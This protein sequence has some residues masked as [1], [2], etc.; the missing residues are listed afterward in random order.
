MDNTPVDMPI[1]MERPPSMREL[2]QE[3][4]EGALS[5]RAQDEQMGTFEEEDD[6]EAD[7][8]D[9]LDL[10]GFEVF[11]HPMAEEDE[12]G[13]VVASEDPP[14]DAPAASEPPPT[15]PPVVEVPSQ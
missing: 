13:T 3:Y 9:L 8:P 12:A 5:Q 7:D 11:E 4:V 15:E 10:S 6:F 1:G 14:V 2:V